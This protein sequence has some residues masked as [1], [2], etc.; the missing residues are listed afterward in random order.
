MERE[1]F[2]KG[3]KVCVYLIGNA[4]IRKKTDEERIK[5][6]TVSS[7]GRRYIRGGLM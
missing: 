1:D 2:H 6:W 7:I 3:Q 4:A 5:E